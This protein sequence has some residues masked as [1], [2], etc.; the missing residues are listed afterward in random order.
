[1]NSEG[2]LKARLAKAE[3]ECESLR[4]EN[5][6]LRLR[7][8][9]TRAIRDPPAERPS[10]SKGERLRPATAVTNDSRPELKVALFRSLFRGRDDVYAIQWQGKSGKTGYS[11]AGIREWEQPASTKFARKKSF[12]LSKPFPLSDQVLRDH[13]IGKQT[14]GVYPLLQDD[15]CW[16]VAVDF[17]K[18]SWEADACAFLKVCR[19]KLA[20]PLSLNVLVQAVEVMFG[21]SLQC[22]NRQQ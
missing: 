14:I 17:D 6:R 13:L 7:V 5:S 8:G 1:V 16:F 2:H 4:Q 9:G 18:K 15:T 12:R 21:Y 19:E 11:P 3:A 20:C 10:P 22:K